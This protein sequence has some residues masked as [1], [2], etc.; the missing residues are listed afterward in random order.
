MWVRYDKCLAVCTHPSLQ[1]L[2]EWTLQSSVGHRWVCWGWTEHSFKTVHGPLNRLVW[3]FLLLLSL[4]STTQRLLCSFL[5][6]LCISLVNT[7][8]EDRQT[9][10]KCAHFC[11]RRRTEF[12]FKWRK[13][14]YWWGQ[15]LFFFFKRCNTK[16]HKCLFKGQLAGSE[17]L[18]SEAACKKKKT[19]LSSTIFIWSHTM[20]SLADFFVS[21]VESKEC[22]EEVD[23]LASGMSRRTFWFVLLHSEYSWQW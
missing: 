20:L 12:F 15:K 17:R 5:Q 7:Q 6:C 19:P 9:P 22:W 4:L 13:L 14:K 21:L 2:N 8:R 16:A 11:T 10:F 1:H 3:S 18:Q 23:S